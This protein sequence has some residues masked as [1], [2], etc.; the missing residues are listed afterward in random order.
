LPPVQAPSTIGL[1][2]TAGEV[3]SSAAPLSPDGTPGGMVA[4]PAAVI[5]AVVPFGLTIGLSAFLLF[6]VEPLV[7]RLVLPVFGGAAGIWATV[8]A[9]FQAMLLLGYL[10]AHLSAT[11]LSVRMGV[12]VHLGIAAVALVATLAAPQRLSEVPIGGLPSLLG[13]AVLLTLIVGPAAFVLASTTPLMSA[14]YART[15]RVTGQAAPRSDPFWLYALSNGASFLALLAYPFLLEPA[16]GLSTQRGVWAA[17][18]GLLAIALVATSLRYLGATRS[19]PLAARQADRAAAPAA[20]V[21][22]ARRIRWLV[23]SAVPAGLLSAV[24]NF[25][26]TDLISAPLLWVVPL[27][28]YLASFVIAFSSRG[29]ARLVPLALILAPAAATL[30]WVPLGSSAGWSILPLLAIEYGGLAIL[31]TA[32]HGRLAADRPPADRLTDFYLTV[33][34]GGVLGGAFVAVVAPLAFDGVWEY[35]LL[36]VGALAALALPVASREPGRAAAGGRRRPFLRLLSG[37]PARIGPYA[38]VAIGLLAVMGADGAIAFEAAVRWLVVGGL[39][40][41][42]G[43]IRWFFAGATALVLVLAT[44]VLPQ[45]ALLRDRSFFGVVEVQ[46]D[47]AGTTLLHGTTVHGGQLLDPARQGDPLSYYA[48]SGPAGDIFA[49]YAAANPAGGDVRVIGL[50]TGS[51]A[52][53]S[54]ESDRMV[55]L[56]I[57]PLVAEVAADPRYF[58]YLANAQGEVGI[59]IGDGRLLLEREGEASLDLV[60][61]DA[62]SS[63]AIPVHLITVEGLAAAGRTLGP[64]GLL[65]IHVSNRYYDLSPAVAAA[66]QRLGLTVLEREYE[67]AAE[68]AARGAGLSHWM[69]AAAS[70][71]A[72]AG[73]LE[74]G[75]VAA[76]VSDRPFT[77]DF[78]DLLRH[79]RAGA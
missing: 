79:L 56:E 47:G 17:G 38:L 1:M 72:L 33:S 8:L 65:A 24:T 76:R 16:I 6:S 32:I 20:E 18:F 46:R 62:F 78:A 15:I 19:E 54:H 48:R 25:I 37:A 2:S 11:R 63:D 45:A 23:L 58:T 77:D 75:W 35:P 74:R 22:L 26:T 34:T 12:M 49:E 10:Y 3:A 69:V 67:P 30:L 4:H 39:V 29:Q 43:G 7:G 73:F 9:F 36:V 52:A 53:Y 13:L 50:G 64:D 61:L 44:F 5:P 66:A 41:L 60:V 40:L 21:A 28:V 55:F 51:L 42:V 31:A 14:W 68:D 70:P 27:A 57:D 71:G 59:Q